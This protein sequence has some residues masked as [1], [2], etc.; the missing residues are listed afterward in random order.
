MNTSISTILA[1]TAIASAAQAADLSAAAPA[2]PLVQLPSVVYA[3]LNVESSIY[4]AQIT[5][6]IHPENYGWEVQCPV[7]TQ[8]NERW[9]YQPAEADRGK[10]HRL[11]VRMWN[12][13]GMIAAATTTVKVAASAVKPE[14]R[15]TVALLGDSLT[16]SGY[17]DYAAKVV[18]E[19]G[20][21][22]YS[23][24]GCHSGDSAS[25]NVK[26]GKV[27]HDGYGGYSW[28]SFQTYY[29]MS[30][31]ELD[32]L[33]SKAERE[34]LEHLGVKI[35]DGPLWR[36]ALLRSPLL[37]LDKD[38]KPK[39]DLL[40]WFKRIDS[41][42]APDV[43]LVELGVN[44]LFGGGDEGRAERTA[45]VMADAN[46]LLDEFRK[47]APNALIGLV[48]QSVGD[49]SQD[50]FGANYGC[51]QTAF[52]FRRNMLAYNRALAELVRTRKDPLIETIP[53]G[54]AVDPVNCYIRRE[55]A[56]NACAHSKVK[57]GANAVHPDAAG[58]RQLGE[59]IGAWMV[60]R[61]SAHP[62]LGAP[63]FGEEP[64]KYWKLEELSAPPASRV[65]PEPDC[66]YK[67]LRPLYLMGRGPGG[68]QREFFAYYGVPKG[69]RPAAGWPGV[70]LVH[71]GGGT[72]FPNFVDLWR[73]AGFAVIALDWYNQRSSP[74]TSPNTNSESGLKRVPLEG[75]VMKGEHQVVVANCVLTHSWLL[76]QPEVDKNRTAMVGLSWGSWYGAAI[77]AVDSRLK[78]MVEIYCGDVKPGQ[79]VLVNGRFLH[80]A[81]T[82][83]WWFV[84]TNDRHVT[85]ESSNAGW[86]ECANLAGFTIV[87]DLP[88]SHVGF[89][90]EGVLRMAKAFCGLEAPLPRLGE[91]S[92]RR[93]MR[94]GA[95][96]CEVRSK[97]LSRGKG[98]KT[99]KVGYTESL[100]PVSWKRPW[101][102]APA[103]L[104]GDEVVGEVSAGTVY[105]YLAAY[106]ENEGKYHDLCGVSPYFAP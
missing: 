75:G 81:K 27:P 60:D 29:K 17:Q 25:F 54:L 64:E 106:E 14:R 68:K 23:P 89:R 26:D 67:D 7:G 12:D 57:R 63:P 47:V 97:L 2:A 58:G 61:F 20:Y 56:A 5:G 87:N 38:G 9:Y 45:K 74:G 80:A 42:R 102:Y 93:T 48:E 51:R 83:M 39:L 49:L 22:N 15:I 4:F 66:V 72:A 24:I 69:E 16:G 40:N 50:A 32:N 10:T 103:K 18:R 91:I 73:E 44:D 28:R 70:V 6:V 8:Q 35:S 13:E 82:P 33:Q 92:I 105:C 11:V 1:V 104:V 84:S 98:V 65:A 37:A 71:G 36:R 101:K 53:A 76:A 19:A 99:F 41:G 62:N 34:Q 95:M 31:E 43:L 94:N 90:F 88:H 86:R 3:M 55:Q 85:P 21:S 96:V 79:E 77:A 46:R 30:V 78:G 52:N 100:D 59:A